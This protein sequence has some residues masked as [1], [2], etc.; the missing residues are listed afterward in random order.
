MDFPVTLKTLLTVPG[1]A[2][3]AA[4]VILWLNQYVPKDKKFYTNI[5]ALCVCE[6][7]AFI[8]AFILY[9]G[10]PS[11]E[12]AFV[13]FLIGLFGTSLQCYGYEGI[14]NFVDFGKPK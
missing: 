6:V 8:A 1:L 12:V 7:L 13:T 10:R 4:V 5:I 3:L 2:I 11:A 14:K 9:D